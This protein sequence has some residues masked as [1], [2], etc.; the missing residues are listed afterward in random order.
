MMVLMDACSIINLSNAHS[1]ERVVLLPDY[2]LAVS[3]TVVG[4]C[5]T[6]AATEIVDLHAAGLL[7]FVD[8]DAVPTDRYFDLLSELA[9]GEGETE[10]IAIA[11]M[12]DCLLCCDD[13]KARRCASD[14]IGEERLMGS[15]RL[16]RFSVHQHLMSGD[17]AMEFYHTMIDCGGFLP[18][19]N[20]EYFTDH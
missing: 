9:L 4:E 14:I 12:R 17:E 19:V 20:L 5:N 15:L 6:G 2:R 10:C 7:D 13:R 8:I 3:P 18:N 16:L 1:L 11:E